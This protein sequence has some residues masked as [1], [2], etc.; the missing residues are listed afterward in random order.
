M[1]ERAIDRSGK[2]REAKLIE[3]TTDSFG[4]MVPGK[5]KE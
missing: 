5:G 3:A 4:P 2:A 1:L